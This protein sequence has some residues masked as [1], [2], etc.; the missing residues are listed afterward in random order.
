MF[1]IEFEFADWGKRHNGFAGNNSTTLDAMHV[2]KRANSKASH[3]LYL[4][5]IE[6]CGIPICL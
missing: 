4:V 1:L 5:S 2:T 6:R 3:V